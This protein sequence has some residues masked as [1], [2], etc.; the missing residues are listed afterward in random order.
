MHNGF[1]K[2]KPSA[3]IGLL[4]VLT[5]CAPGPTYAQDQAKPLEVKYW[6]AQ[7]SWRTTLLQRPTGDLMCMVNALGKEPH[8]F[9]VSIIETPGSLMFA[10]DDRNSTQGYLPTMAVQIDKDAPQVFTTFNDPPMT[11]TAPAEATRVRVLVTRLARGQSLT[12]DA[13]RAQYKLSLDGF[14]SAAAQLRACRLEVATTPPGTV[15]RGN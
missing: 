8:A 7:G 13:R 2:L 15:G 11:S 4:A 10:I 6:P 12:V 5:I 14:R 3:F 9:G 1:L